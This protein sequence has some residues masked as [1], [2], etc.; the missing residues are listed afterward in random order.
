MVDI[1]KRIE[2]LRKRLAK[3]EFGEARA[4][5]VARADEILKANGMIPK[6]VEPLRKEWVNDLMTDTQ[7]YKAAV[8]D[9]AAHFLRWLSDRS[10][11]RY[12]VNRR[13][14]DAAVE[15][16]GA[17]IANK[18][19]IIVWPQEIAWCQRM[20][21]DRNP[22]TA[23][24]AAL[25]LRETEGN[26]SK[27][28]AALA[29]M[30]SDAAARG[31]YIDSPAQD[32]SPDEIRFAS[33]LPDFAPLFQRYASRAYAEA[34]EKMSRDQVEKYAARAALEETADRRRVTAVGIAAKTR[35]SPMRHQLSMIRSAMS[36]GLTSNRMFLLEQGFLS[37][38]AD[39]KIEM[40]PGMRTA[41]A[42]FLRM[43]MNA[44]ERK[45][46]LDM[47]P[48]PDPADHPDQWEIVNLNGEFLDRLP[49][50]FKA[51]GATRKTLEKWQEAI[52]EGA[53]E[54]PYDAESDFA[55]FVLEN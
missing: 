9:P 50:S 42:G 24:K 3:L 37:Q 51:L 44:T 5:V 30:Y 28:F 2:L 17:A 23:T 1:D 33:E 11:D 27:T 29:D 21:L 26:P 35:R 7:S 47:Q 12:R 41:D 4:D 6:M 14:I 32:F 34:L 10:R 16:F 8:G 43:L 38:V 48:L 22:Y 49:A 15:K 39:G 36:Q 25:F 19:H 40:E 53:R 18:L 20:R 55:F 52:V 45:R 31:G 54:I 13:S 46:I